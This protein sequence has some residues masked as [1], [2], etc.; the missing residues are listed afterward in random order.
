MAAITDAVRTS[1]APRASRAELT[2]DPDLGPAAE[3]WNR[4][5][6]RMLGLDAPSATSP[7]RARSSDPVVDSLADGVLVI[8][9]SLVIETAN[10]SAAAL[11][12]SDTDNLTGLS[13]VEVGPPVL[14]ELAETVLAGGPVQRQAIEF[15]TEESPQ[16]LRVRIARLSGSRDRAVV[17]LT[18]ITRQSVA[19]ASRGGFL[20]RATHELRAPL[21]NVKLYTEQAIEEGDDD[22]Q[23]R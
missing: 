3:D 19:E 2:I 17:T 12:A 6:G 21:T 8:D 14:G 20:A 1:T 22:P 18:D 4:L 11:L 7:D 5:V 10:P 23:L 16:I 13:L 15:G 9:R